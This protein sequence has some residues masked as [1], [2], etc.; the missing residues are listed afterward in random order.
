MMSPHFSATVPPRHPCP[1][2]RPVH[3]A[4]VSVPPGHPRHLPRHL[5]RTWAHDDVSMTSSQKGANMPKMHKK[6]SKNS[7]FALFS[8]TPGAPLKA[9]F[10]PQ[11]SKRKSYP[12]KLLPPPLSTQL[13]TIQP[14]RPVQAPRTPLKPGILPQAPSLV[15]CSPCNPIFLLKQLS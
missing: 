9:K 15:H 7:Y 6:A 3:P 10:N 8:T 14:I 12:P 5:F 1:P 13:P 11:R 2:H 4:T